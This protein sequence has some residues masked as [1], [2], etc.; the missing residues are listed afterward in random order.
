M[1]IHA[2]VFIDYTYIHIY[3]Y[4]LEALIDGGFRGVRRPYTGGGSEWPQGKTAWGLYGCLYKFGDPFCAR[5][6][7]QE[8]YR[9]GSIS[10]PLICGNFPMPTVGSNNLGYGCRMIHAGFPSFLG[11]GLED[12]RSVARS[13]Y[14][15]KGS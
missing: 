2:H 5:P 13:T 14:H 12:C 3:I 8:P 9:L 4:D 1:Y 6:H 10:G 15:G 11:L 7:N